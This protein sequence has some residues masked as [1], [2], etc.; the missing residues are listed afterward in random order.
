[1]C[2]QTGGLASGAMRTIAAP[3]TIRGMREIN[4]EKQLRLAVSLKSILWKP[5]SGIL[6]LQGR[7]VGLSSRSHHAT[8]FRLGHS[9]R[10]AGG[11]SAG[12]RG[13]RGV[14][15]R[16]IDVLAAGASRAPL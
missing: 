3:S 7:H 10:F 14:R 12:V 4:E 1:Y 15:M 9:P 8:R 16:G 2:E 11:R 5:R 13:G 6:D